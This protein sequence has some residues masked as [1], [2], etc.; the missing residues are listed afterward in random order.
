M[1]PDSSEA[2][3]ARFPVRYI[4]VL[5]LMVISAAVYL[6]RINISIAAIG[7]CKEFA[8]SKVQM[9][10]VF[11]A[12]LIGYAGLQIPAGVLARRLGPRLTLGL[13]G[14]WN[15]VFIVLIAF[16]PRGIG[17]PLVLLILLRFFLGAGEATM[18]PATSQFVER[19]FPVSERGKANGLIFAGIG[20]SGLTPPLMTAIILHYGWRASFCF[21]ASAGALV[22]LVWYLA[23]RN[24]PEQHK[25]V[26]DA[27]RELIVSQ[28][29]VSKV[30]VKEDD[31]AQYGKHKI[32]WRQIF[33]SKAVL[34]ITLSYFAFGYVAWMFYTWFYTY[35]AQVRGLNL[36]TS[37][38]Y[39]MLPFLA[40]TAGCLLG[41]VLS[42]WIVTHYG[43]RQGRC[44]L[45]ALALAI[46][47]F[48]LVMGSRIESAAAAAFMLAF[49]AG[50][51]FISQSIYWAVTADISGE[52]VGVVSGI[53]NMGGQ[54]GGACTAALTPVIA[55]HF[56]WN[57]S[58]ATA[59]AITAIG[60]LAWT[61]ID[62]KRDVLVVRE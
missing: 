22:G 53:M 16:I 19:W 8:I 17:N 39:S 6:D 42:D 61:A 5:W 20:L 62:P 55:A 15:P 43:A 59:A 23:A 47:A 45:P 52:Y 18:F 56:G 49:G 21:G 11:S 57:A 3:S 58:F 28:R 7:I 9:G 29:R 41:G 32:P 1:K 27:E 12:F 54:V 26:G 48:L 44:L 2:H 36:K 38:L 40:M 24:T 25:W 31:A 37:A 13:L 34:A 30:A 60:A 33:S 14:V 10:W 46:T 50:V 4:L 51:L 35:M